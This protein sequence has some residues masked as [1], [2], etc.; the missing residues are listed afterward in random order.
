[1]VLHYPDPGH[2]QR[3]FTLIELLVVIAVISVLAAILFPVFARARENARRARCMSNLKQFGM[4]LMMYVQDYDETYPPNQTVDLGIEPPGGRWLGST[5]T[6]WVWEQLLQPYIKSVQIFT[7]P[8]GKDLNSSWRER[9]LRG[10]YGASQYLFRGAA[11]TIKLSTVVSPA[12]T[13]AMMDAG[14]VYMVTA[15]AIPNSG[16]DRASYG[17][18]LP[19]IGQLGSSCEATETYANLKSDCESGRHL[20]GINMAFADGHVKWLK[21]ETITTEARKP[22]GN[23]NP[24]PGGVW[25][26]ENPG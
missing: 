25:R 19:G 21:T 2:R 15:Y 8:S 13:Y 17:Y 4:G 6:A 23:G 1:M 16:S 12:T 7:C 3:A 9:P 22:S 5:S 10:H 20:G 24:L 18:Y 11:S 26:P 14:Y